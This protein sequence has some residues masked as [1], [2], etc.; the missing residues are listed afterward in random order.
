[1]RNGIEIDGRKT[2]PAEVTVLEEQENRVV[3]EF[4]LHEGRN[5]EIRKM[6]ESQGLEVARLKRNSIGSLKLGMLKQGQYRELTEQE[7]KKLLRS[8]GQGNN[9]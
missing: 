3:L 9:N 1:M 8:A 4:I 6:C 2:A 5:R 7:V